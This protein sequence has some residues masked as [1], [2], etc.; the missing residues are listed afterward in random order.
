MP[1]LI[2]PPGIQSSPITSETSVTTARLGLDSNSQNE[3][4]ALIAINGNRQKKEAQTMRQ[5][6]RLLTRHAVASVASSRPNAMPGNT[7]DN[8]GT[9]NMATITATL[10]RNCTAT[11]VVPPPPA[12]T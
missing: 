3:I 9:M 1:T 2:M 10:T 5:V 4:A 11:A 6:L 8:L 7:S 12:M